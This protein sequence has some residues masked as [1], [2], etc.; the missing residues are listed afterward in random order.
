MI[1]LTLVLGTLLMP[2]EC[3]TIDEVTINAVL[4]LSE[5]DYDLAD[6]LLLQFP[7]LRPWWAGEIEFQYTDQECSDAQTL[8][9]LIAFAWYAIELNVMRQGEFA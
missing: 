6:S 5:V 2:L 8:L 1:T 3:P 4:A 7:S 9:T